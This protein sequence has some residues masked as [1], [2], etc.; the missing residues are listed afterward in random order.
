MVSRFIPM[1]NFVS[2]RRLIVERILSLIDAEHNE[3]DIDHAMSRW[4]RNIRST[5]GLGLTEFGDTEFRRAEL[6]HWDFD[7]TEQ[8]ISKN[9][10]TFFV[11][12]D[13]KMICPYFVFFK[14]KR[15]YIRI[16]DGRVATILILHGNIKDF[17][18]TLDKRKR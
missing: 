8:E 16:Y 17:L 18:D 1:T 12:L 3:K 14:D 11:L 6:E 15:K 5:G 13:N 9:I 2:D 10:I 4:W 7:I